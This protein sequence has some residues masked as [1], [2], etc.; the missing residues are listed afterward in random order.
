MILSAR[1]TRVL[2]AAATVRSPASAVEAATND[3]RCPL[4]PLPPVLWERLGDE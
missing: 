4:R 3:P 2:A 1:T